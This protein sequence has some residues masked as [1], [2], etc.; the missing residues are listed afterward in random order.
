MVRN[1]ETKA[2]AR[3]EAADKRTLELRDREEAASPNIREAREADLR[4]SAARQAQEE[5][6]RRQ[7]WRD[8][9]ER[10]LDVAA[11]WPAIVALAEGGNEDAPLFLGAMW[12]VAVWRNAGTDD[13]KCDL[14]R[15]R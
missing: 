4:A 6:A 12:Q 10:K 5:A 11:V 15:R 1:A 13:A 2:A 8:E 7:R 14:G 3:R 9:A